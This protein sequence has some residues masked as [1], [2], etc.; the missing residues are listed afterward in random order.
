M[1]KGDNRTHRQNEP[2]ISWERCVTLR[3]W[4][5]GTF[6]APHAALPAL[7]ERRP[8]LPPAPPNRVTWSTRALQRAPPLALRVREPWRVWLEGPKRRSGLAPRKRA[9]PKHRRAPRATSPRRQPEL[10]AD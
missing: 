8:I 4:R 6:R 10:R 5:R 3:R 2:V 9:R 7:R 1:E